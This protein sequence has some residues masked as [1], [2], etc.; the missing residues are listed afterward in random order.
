MDRVFMNI[1]EYGNTSSASVP[2]A[3]YEAR[4]SGKIRPGDVVV[5]V[6]FGGGLAWSA[7]VM[8]WS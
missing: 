5:T 1:G 6:G 7:L 2:L 8:R 4:K 3:L